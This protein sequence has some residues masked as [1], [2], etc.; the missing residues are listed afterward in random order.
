[1]K[2]IKTCPICNEDNFNFLFRCKDYSTSKESF[3]I[4]SCNSC[5]FTFTNPRPEKENL[6][7]YYISDNYI[8]HTNTNK[9]LFEILYQIIRKY[10]IV[11]KPRLVKKYSE[12]KSQKNLLIHHDIGKKDIITV[13]IQVED[14]I[15]KT[16]R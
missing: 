3:T 5:N 11:Q 7:K 13:V 4:V 12:V 8:S 16:L 1:M 9:G 10:A 2:K 14:L 6:E 15:M